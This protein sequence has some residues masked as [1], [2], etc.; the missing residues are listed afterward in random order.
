M[1]ADADFPEVERA[2]YKDL[3]RFIGTVWVA[4]GSCLTLYAVP[5]CISGFAYR[6]AFLEV[7][8]KPLIGDD[9]SFGNTVINGW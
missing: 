1:T 2:A 3:P 9:F 5:F 6:L 8:G 7:F 4:L